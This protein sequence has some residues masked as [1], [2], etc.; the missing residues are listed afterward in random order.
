MVE[1]DIYLHT[2]NETIHAGHHNAS[3]SNHTGSHHA[4]SFHNISQDVNSEIIQNIDYERMCIAANMAIGSNKQEF[5]I[6][7]DTGSMMFWIPSTM[8]HDCPSQAKFNNEQSK[9]FSF[10]DIV[11]DL[12]Y[13]SGD[14]YGYPSND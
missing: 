13:G 6:L 5:K 11:I 12:H 4:S 7:L 2:S 8:C 14:V 1:H 9:T 3:A 10:Y